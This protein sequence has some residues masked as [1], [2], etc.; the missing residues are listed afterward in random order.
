MEGMR[1]ISAAYA[2]KSLCTFQARRSMHSATT[3]MQDTG[4]THLVH[5]C[6]MFLRWLSFLTHETCYNWKSLHYVTKDLVHS[7]SSLQKS[8][9]GTW[10]DPIWELNPVILIGE[11]MPNH[12]WEVNSITGMSA[13]LCIVKASGHNS[14]SFLDYRTPG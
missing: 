9:F 7:K 12:M 14:E 6:S 2:T 11:Y 10:R 3:L 8:S 13:P 4:R 1:G 5:H